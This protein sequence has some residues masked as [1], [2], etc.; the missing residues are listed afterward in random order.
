MKQIKWDFKFSSYSSVLEELPSICKAQSSMLNTVNKRGPENCL[1]IEKQIK[2]TFVFLY[3][4]LGQ[5]TSQIVLSASY[6]GPPRVFIRE[7][8]R[9]QHAMT[10][11]KYLEGT[12]AFSINSLRI[13]RIPTTDFDN[14]YYPFLLPQL[15][16]AYHTHSQLPPYLFISP[17]KIPFS[18]APRLI[19]QGHPSTRA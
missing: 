1:K 18:V 7:G 17:P 11:C 16:P 6:R 13:S 19:G 4:A 15:P 3:F 12:N 2:Y 9:N 8:R 5:R 10:Y 14:I